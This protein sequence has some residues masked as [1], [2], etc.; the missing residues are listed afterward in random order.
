MF[1]VDDPMLAL[2][3]R[4]VMDADH[5]EVSNDRFLREQVQAIEEYVGQ[6]PE[7]QRQSRALEW[8]AEHAKHYRIAWQ[9]RVVV[10][11]LTQRRCSDC[12][13][14]RDEAGSRCKIHAE[15]S[16]LLQDYLDEKVTSR[17]YVED[18]LRLLKDNK[19]MLLPPRV[20]PRA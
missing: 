13:L 7:D 12:P 6:F 14:V 4:F 17:G 11:G 5:L 9:R 8:I 19:S 15:W 10:D 1:I 18:A 3:A 16:R 20:A 2:I